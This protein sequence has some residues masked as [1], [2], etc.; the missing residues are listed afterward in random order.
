[1][2]AILIDLRPQRHEK[3]EVTPSTTCLLQG[4][5]EKFIGFVLDSLR[6]VH[7]WVHV[8]TVPSNITCFECSVFSTI[9]TKVDFCLTN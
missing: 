8:E 1:M 7:I 6:H 3:T 4:N 2:Q 9:H 5:S